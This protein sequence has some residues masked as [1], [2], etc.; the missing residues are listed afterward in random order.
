MSADIAGCDVSYTGHAGGFISVSKFGTSHWGNAGYSGCITDFAVG[1]SYYQR[2]NSDD[3]H[4]INAHWWGN[5]NEQTNDYL[6]HA[7]FV[8]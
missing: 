5:G 7:V 8:R 3:R 6:T 1:G 4:A 2:S